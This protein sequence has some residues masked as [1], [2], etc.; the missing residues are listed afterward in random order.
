MRSTDRISALVLLAI[1]GYFWTVTAGFNRLGRLFPRTI[2]VT[3]GV[4]AGVQLVSTFLP[5]AEKLK[6]KKAFGPISTSYTEIGLAA[7]LIVAWAFLLHLIGFAV[8]SFVFFSVIAVVFEK[9]HKPFTY[10]MVKVA[11]I[12]LSIAVFYYFF[13]SLL[14]VPFPRGLLF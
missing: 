10:Y 8:T 4:L 9:R 14:R 1:C 2:I 3:L 5:R 6:E 7:G 11:S 12:G 13:S